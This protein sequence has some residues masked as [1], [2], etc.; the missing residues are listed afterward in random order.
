MVYL[1]ILLVLTVW[2]LDITP[3]SINHVPLKKNFLLNFLVRESDECKSLGLSTT[4]SLFQ[5]N[6]H[7][8][9]KWFKILSNIVL[10]CLPWKSKDDQVR[11]LILRVFILAL[12]LNNAKQCKK[13]FQ[14]WKYIIQGSYPQQLNDLIQ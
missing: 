2:N 3:S 1:S 10:C 14:Q 8:L 5:L 11:G 13:N 4:R 6:H 12:N 9:P 7:N